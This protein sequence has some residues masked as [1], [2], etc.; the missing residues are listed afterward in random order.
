MKLNEIYWTLIASDFQFDVGS[1]SFLHW[2]RGI[3]GNSSSKEFLTVTKHEEEQG[4]PASIP[5]RC[6]LAKFKGKQKNS[7]GDCE[8][9]K[10]ER[11]RMKKL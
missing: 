3:H 6:N 1:L 11:K 10:N 7:L 4:K 2:Q 8:Q 5:L 9:R